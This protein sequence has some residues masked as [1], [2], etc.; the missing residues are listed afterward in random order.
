MRDQARYQKRR[1]KLM[2]YGSLD[3]FE[4]ELEYPSKLYNSSHEHMIKTKTMA[5]HV[6]TYFNE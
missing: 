2:I 4:G 3:Q 6:V 1:M 5:D